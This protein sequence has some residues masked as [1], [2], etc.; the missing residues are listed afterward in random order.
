MSNQGP[1]MLVHSDGA[2][3][4]CEDCATT[5]GTTMMVEDMFY[6]APGRQKALRTKDEYHRMVQLVG[7]YAVSHTGVSLGIRRQ[8][9]PSDVQTVAGATQLANIRY[10][11][12]F[13]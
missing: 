6:N 8:G 12:C 5:P 13:L 1:H 9:M 4:E 3:L 7:H 11:I 2:M 10:R